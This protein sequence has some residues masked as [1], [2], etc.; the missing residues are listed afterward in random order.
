MRTLN[1]ITSSIGNLISNI[2]TYESSKINIR[3]VKESIEYMDLDYKINV[4]KTVVKEIEARGNISDS[5]K[6]ALMGINE[7]LDRIN[8]ELGTVQKAIEYHNSK[9]FCGYR[10]FNC[11]CNIEQIIKHNE[12]LDSRYRILLDLI[13]LRMN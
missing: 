13:K 1:A 3:S 8:D 2:T 9:Y 4:I 12:I 10:S 5:V 7:V 11:S 6:L